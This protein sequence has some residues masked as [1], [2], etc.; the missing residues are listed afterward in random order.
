MRYQKKAIDDHHV[1]LMLDVI[2]ELN[3]AM[4]EGRPVREGFRPV[5]GMMLAA[6]GAVEVDIIRFVATVMPDR[7]I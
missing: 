4:N 7:K 1:Q 5:V 3:A 2:A 6:R